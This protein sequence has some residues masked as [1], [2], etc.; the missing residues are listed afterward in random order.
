MLSCR[1]APYVGSR[2]VEGES[3]PDHERTTSMSLRGPR[4][5]SPAKPTMNPMMMVDIIGNMMVSYQMDGGCIRLDLNL[6]VL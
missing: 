2:Q 6:E 4:P 3:L 1:Q 5:A